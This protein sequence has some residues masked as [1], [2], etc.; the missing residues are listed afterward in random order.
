MPNPNDPRETAHA[1]GSR[2]RVVFAGHNFH[3]ARPL[4]QHVRQNDRYEPLLDSW[5]GHARHDE[6]SSARCRD[7][8]DVVFCEWCLGNAVWYSKHKRPGQRLIV[9]LHR[10]EFFG[11]PRAR[12]LE[13]VDWDAV[14]AAITIAP[15]F[16]DKLVASGVVP[17]ERVHFIPNLF[18]TRSFRIEK[19][20]E[21]R[22]SIG[23]VKLAPM[24]KRPDMAV[25]ILH[26]LKSSESRFRLTFIDNKPEE[27]PWLWKRL[28]ERSFLDGFFE[29]VEASPHRS[30]I[31]FDDYTDDVPAWF[32][33]IGILLSTSDSEGSHQAVAE[34]MASG[35][36]PIIRDWPGADRLYPK[37]FVYSSVQEAVERILRASERDRFGQLSGFAGDFAASHFDTRSVAP[38]ITQLF[39]RP[40]SDQPHSQPVRT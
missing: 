2:T 1:D 5:Q 25:E 39:H 6:S 26:R 8:A 11:K 14:D 30:S 16:R 36:V 35:A 23:V 32:S 40:L 13:N 19:P 27:K 28:A 7:E 12:F 18:D 10:Q 34:G 31:S 20:A 4:I 38:R 21:A 22:F 29:A 15:H 37:R 9:R 17:P 33:R 3:F 24:R